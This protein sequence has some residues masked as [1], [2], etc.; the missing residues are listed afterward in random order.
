MQ[1]S[2]RNRISTIVLDAAIE[3]HKILG[4]GM[5]ESV[6]RACF[7]KELSLRGIQFE[8]NIQFPVIY[9]NAQVDCSLS[10][11]L[12]IENEVIVD[13]IAVEKTL[14]SNESKLLS[15][16]Q[17]SNKNIAILINFNVPRLIDG[18]KKFTKNF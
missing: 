1:L 12:L 6:Y 3:V 14:Q 13:I 10:C 8:K 18:F 5:T 15:A 7:C 17:I 16:I 11:D 2:D 4:P 9:K